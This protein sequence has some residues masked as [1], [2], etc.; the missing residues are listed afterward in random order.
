[1]N[2]H[3]Q[4]PNEL[5]PDGPGNH[6]KRKGEIQSKTITNCRNVTLIVENL[7]TNKACRY[8]TENGD[9][10]DRI[11]ENFRSWL[12]FLFS[13]ELHNFHEQFSQG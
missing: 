5:E 4:K 6:S 9:A 7:A 1:M 2:I 3:L 11:I 12:F 13:L 10:N 8:T